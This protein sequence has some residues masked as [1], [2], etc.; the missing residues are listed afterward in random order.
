LWLPV[1]LLLVAGA[2]V[3]A[4]IWH[5][6]AS[7]P[8]LR[9][10]RAAS[11]GVH[12]DNE[13]KSTKKKPGANNSA[14]NGLDQTT[15][16]SL[17]I[18]PLFL[19]A[20]TTVIAGAGLTAHFSEWHGATDM[21]WFALVGGLVHFVAWI[22]GGRKGAFTNQALTGLFA[23]LTGALGGAGIWLLAEKVFPSRSS[24]SYAGFAAPAL[25]LIYLL[26]TTLYVGLCSFWTSDEDREWWARAGAWIMIFAAGIALF[27]L[28]V[29]YGVQ[30][31]INAGIYVRSAITAT[32]GIAGVASALLGKSE[33]TEGPG[34]AGSSSGVSL[35][36]VAAKLAAPVF[37]VVVL[38]LIA[39]GTGSLLTLIDPTIREAVDAEHQ[40]GLYGKNAPQTP[41]AAAPPLVGA[42]NVI[43]NGKKYDVS[44]KGASEATQTP[45][46]MWHEHQFALRHTS[47][48]MLC[49][50]MIV[51]TLL[52]WYM[53]YPININKFSLQAMYRD[54][55]I[56][57]YL[58]ASAKDRKPDPFTGFDD[59]D[60]I[61]MHQLRGQRPFHVLN[62]TLNLAGGGA[63][64]AWQERQAE[65]F[66]V[67]PLHTGSCS[68]QMQGAYRD[69]QEYASYP[70]KEKT[71]KGNGK[72]KKSA[73]DYG[74]TLGSAVA[75][76]GA[77]ANPNMGYNTSPLV[78]FLMTLFNTRLGA[79]L[80]NPGNT[81]EEG[82][83]RLLKKDKQPPWTRSGPR[84]SVLP[85]FAEA[86]ALADDT[87]P[88]VCL[89]DGGHFE[90]LGLYEMVLRRCQFIMV[91]DNGADVEYV[92]DALANAIQKIRVDLKVDI[93]VPKFTNIKVEGI[94]FVE[95]LIH[96]P[97][98]PDE[99]C[100]IVYVKPVLTRV[101]SQDEPPDI[102]YYHSQDNTFPQQTTADQWFDESQ[103]E[104]YRMLGEHTVEK[105]NTD[106]WE[107]FI[108]RKDGGSTMSRG[109]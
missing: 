53:G 57:A 14:A 35:A 85:L 43:V 38:L 81:V 109:G 10:K 64:L 96:Y 103:F 6:N 86:L 29:I 72:S 80:G 65:S 84:H 16:L 88:Y 18:T 70:E 22:F 105:M 32:G 21:V 98:A 40:A 83:W 26:A 50:L 108:A 15:F 9:K 106:D 13:A 90:N 62:M 7:L 73:D 37:A 71:N 107:K 101:P 28:L 48:R 69:S 74:I 91:L 97:E 58:G 99:V 12:D 94:H 104:S 34:A 100:K 68:L 76:S 55:L 27:N 11:A 93:E 75:I 20:E 5:V 24:L 47:L 67:S 19:A 30:W 56:R 46:P 39:L 79:W 51:L 102:F 41:P 33:K 78:A 25:I 36:S 17:V 60:N 82:L 92:F 66:T 95:G 87:S 3:A 89:S 59:N 4:A 23:F 42:A 49:L 31:L 54:R 8:S 2:L 44:V 77:A 63:N 1:A 45:A 61:R 52:G